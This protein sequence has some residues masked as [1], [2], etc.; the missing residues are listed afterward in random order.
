MS[1]AVRVVVPAALSGIMASVILG[2]SRAIGETMIVTLAMGSNPVLCGNPL[3][4]CQT[5]T[6]YIA[7]ASFGD[8]PQTS[9]EFKGIFAVGSVLFF[10]TLWMNLVSQRLVRRFRQVY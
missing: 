2:V 8:T 9:L 5:L 3:E 10:L 6:A 4:S 1:V 7:Q